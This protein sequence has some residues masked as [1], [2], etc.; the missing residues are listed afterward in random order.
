MDINE[1]SGYKRFAPYLGALLLFITLMLVRPIT[2]HSEPVIQCQVPL[3]VQCAVNETGGI[4]R[5]VVKL[6][7]GLGV[8]EAVDNTYSGCP[9]QVIVSWDPIVPNAEIIVTPCTDP[10]VGSFVS[11]PD[12]NATPFINRKLDFTSFD[13][14]GDGKPDIARVLPSAFSLIQVGTPATP[15]GIT[16]VCNSV[17]ACEIVAE[18]CDAGGGTGSCSRDQCV[19][20]LP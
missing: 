19:C 17:S 5:V 15:L 7:T 14:D 4:A 12:T 3:N 11:F 9:T 13:R 10:D 6:E 16:L 8:V 18:I 1:I 20:E 2:A